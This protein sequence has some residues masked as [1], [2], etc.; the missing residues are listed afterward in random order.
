MVFA[1]GEI[2]TA[3]KLNRYTNTRVA[4]ARRTT[5]S[6]GSTSTTSVGV[7]RLDDIP[8]FA[9][10]SYKITWKA[11]FDVGTAADTMRGIIRHTTDGATP[12]TSSAILPGS[13]GE[14]LFTL[15]TSAF[16]C[17]IETD[18][19]PS[20]DQ[21]L[22]LLLCVQHNSGI[23]AGIMQADGTTFTTDMYVD[24]VGDDPGNTGTSV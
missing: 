2:L 18:Y 16:G 8:V 4:R 5:N 14:A 10:I 1:A 19:T 22:S 24:L 15:N 7:L 13:G 3:A 17:T 6:S 23:S 20:S 9:G 11:N 21:L 12:S